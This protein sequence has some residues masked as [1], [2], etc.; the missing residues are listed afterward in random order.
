MAGDKQL[1]T[2]GSRGVFGRTLPAGLMRRL[3]YKFGADTNWIKPHHVGDVWHI[4][5]RYT[6]G[7]ALPWTYAKSQL[8]GVYLKAL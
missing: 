6:C 8:L 5:W 7:Q 2:P 1:Q 4:V 3:V